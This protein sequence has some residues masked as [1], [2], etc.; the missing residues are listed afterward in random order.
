V[1]WV[2]GQ[3]SNPLSR[4]GGHQTKWSAA[5][6]AIRVVLCVR[7]RVHVVI[8]NSAGILD[9]RHRHR[10]QA[11]RYI[12]GTRYNDK[13]ARYHTTHAT[14]YSRLEVA[15]ARLSTASMHLLDVVEDYI[16]QQDASGPTL[17]LKL[18]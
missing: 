14:G 3:E 17:R 6:P 15:A 11:Q 13:V 10:H 9:R 2:L 1:F 16:Y 12:Q 7:V 8:R 18:R 4:R 5:R